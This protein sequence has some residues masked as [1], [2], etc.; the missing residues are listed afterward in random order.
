MPLPAALAHAGSVVLG[1]VLLLVLALA[2]FAVD[3]CAA[4]A[5]PAGG[6]AEDEPRRR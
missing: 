4:A 6:A 3:R 5:P 1:G 2:L